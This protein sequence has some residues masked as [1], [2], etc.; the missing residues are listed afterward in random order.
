[1]KQHLSTK[2]EYAQQQ[3]TSATIA[4][5][6]ALKHMPDGPAKDMA[7]EATSRVHKAC[8]VLQGV[9]AP[10]GKR[11]ALDLEAPLNDP[12]GKT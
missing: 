12:D 11:H 7:L 4:F 1:M 2:L 5:R 6:T 9:D 10:T 8:R 3:L